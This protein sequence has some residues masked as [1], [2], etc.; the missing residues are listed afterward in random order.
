[1]TIRNMTKYC[2]SNLNVMKRKWREMKSCLCIFYS[3]EE[4]YLEEK[5]L[6]LKRNS[7]SWKYN[8]M[9][10]TPRLS[11]IAACNQLKLSQLYISIYL[12]RRKLQKLWS[13]KAIS[14][15]VNDSIEMAL[16]YQADLL[17]KAVNALCITAVGN[18]WRS[19]SI[20]R[21]W[22]KIE[23]MKRRS[24]RQ[25]SFYSAA[26]AVSLKHACLPRSWWLNG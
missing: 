24:R 5:C 12:C 4:I 20:W 18:V 19:H 6:K 25:S 14:L 13:E 21:K 17:L 22:E 9:K 11:L 2:E 23:S 26:V 16:S 1:M 15:V 3:E 10:A 8:K 7:I